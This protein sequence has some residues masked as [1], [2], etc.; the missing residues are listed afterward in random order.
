MGWLTKKHSFTMT[1]G[2]VLF[3]W[4]EETKR[5][6]N[7]IDS[8]FPTQKHWDWLSTGT[9]PRPNPYEIGSE[10]HDIDWV[11][12]NFFDDL[13]ETIPSELVQ[14]SFSLLSN[15]PFAIRP[16]GA[17]LSLWSYLDP[18]IMYRQ[19]KIKH[20]TY[21]AFFDSLGPERMR[22]EHGFSPNR[23]GLLEEVRCTWETLI[24]S[25]DSEERKM[26]SKASDFYSQHARELKDWRE[27]EAYVAMQ[28]FRDEAAKRREERVAQIEGQLAVQVRSEVNEIRAAYSQQFA[29]KAQGKLL[30]VTRPFEEFIERGLPLSFECT[31][32]IGSSEEADLLA[33]HISLR[34]EIDAAVSRHQFDDLLLVEKLNAGDAKPQILA[35]VV[36]QRL[37][38]CFSTVRSQVKDRLTEAE[39]HYFFSD[40]EFGLCARPYVWLSEL[41][42]V[43]R[44]LDEL[45]GADEGSQP[46][47]EE[48]WSVADKELEEFIRSLPSQNDFAGGIKLVAK[49][50]VFQHAQLVW[51]TYRDSVVVPWFRITW[52]KTKDKEFLRRSLDRFLPSINE[53]PVDVAAQ[54]QVIINPVWNHHTVGPAGKVMIIRQ[55]RR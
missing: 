17:F 3:E 48:N 33:F 24:Q 18:L 15:N 46:I 45:A 22:A 37:K 12:S 39:F 4:C 7:Y 41:R 42:R 16:S 1:N 13:N 5:V 26:I 32:T 25:L 20:E 29:D 44:I 23:L 9:R 54:V 51:Q 2:F 19:S 14:P 8:L 21:L 50:G 38:R 36:F 34:P 47:A 40:L 10:F 11:A 31:K 28:P 35:F 55:K 52:D 27:Q 6:A 43:A 49:H 30:S 53:D